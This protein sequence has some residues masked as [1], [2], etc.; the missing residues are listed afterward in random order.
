M[1]KSRFLLNLIA[2]TA[3][4]LGT[5]G[6]TDSGQV[7][8]QTNSD[9]IQDDA[10]VDVFTR[11]FLLVSQRGATPVPSAY[12]DHTSAPDASLFSDLLQ[13]TGLL[14]DGV[15]SPFQLFELEGVQDGQNKATPGSAQGYDALAGAH[16]SYPSPDGKY[17]IALSRARNLDK[18]ANV[19]RSGLAIYAIKT[20]EES[21]Y[22]HQ[23]SIGNPQDPV[24]MSLVSGSQGEFASGVW[25]PDS[26]MF[27]TSLHGLVYSYIFYGDVG[28]ID[29]PQVLDFPDGGVEDANNAVTMI[30]SN[31][32]RFIY[33]LDNANA[34]I[35]R[36]RRNS[37]GRLS[38]ADTT[39][40]VADP[41]GMAVDRS[42]KFIYVTGRASGQLAGYSISNQTEGS[43][44]D[45]SL[46]PIDIFNE[47]AVSHDFGF[48]LG[49]IATNP[50]AD[51]L[52]VA[53]YT[54][55]TMQAYGINPASGALSAQGAAHSGIEGSRNTANIKIDPTGHFVIQANEHGLEDLVVR[56][57]EIGAQMF[58]NI[59]S[60]NNSGDS[61]H[62]FSPIEMLDKNGNPVYIDSKATINFKGN[63][64]IWRLDGYDDH[65]PRAEKLIEV[66]NP[67]GISFFG[68]YDEP[69]P[70]D[71][72]ADATPTPTPTETP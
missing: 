66:T 24:P 69:S 63:V 64:Q 50:K 49:S 55:G 16:Q 51:E 22:P 8:F 25:S 43:P 48:K 42:G 5:V 67:Y 20:D 52:V 29:S 28:R 17:V 14:A 56:A 41:R 59:D 12:D 27:Y 60:D 10:K 26:K 30:M 35:V 57:Q 61:G 19:D 65:A 13:V 9:L 37:D 34:Q 6:C 39:P 23:V 4:G 44:A 38:L 46:S 62:A 70:D 15:G 54:G 68:I 71:V 36:Y 18:V 1:K 3:I 53:G 7:A 58:A 11:Q 31:N 45:G 2:A 47:G 72:P 40:T 32:G 21:D 33:A